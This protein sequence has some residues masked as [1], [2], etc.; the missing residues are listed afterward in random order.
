MSDHEGEAMTEDEKQ[1]AE[2]KRLEFLAEVE[3]A[4]NEIKK[5]IEQYDVE[6][7]TLQERRASRKAEQAMWLEK[8][9]KNEEE[10]RQRQEEENRRLREAAEQKKRE[11]EERRRAMQ[12][13]NKFQPVIQDERVRFAKMTPAE[14]AKEKEETLAKRVPTLDPEAMTSDE[15]MREIARE[16]HAKIMKAFGALFDLQEKEKRQ[17]YDINE[18]TSRIDAIQKDKLKASLNAEGKIQKLNIPF[19]EAAAE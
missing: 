15:V 3:A 10:R 1:L 8:I 12:N 13:P 16:L 6:I 11:R 4:R 9:K 5:V 17:K 2:E 14:L 18:L 7:S 19:G